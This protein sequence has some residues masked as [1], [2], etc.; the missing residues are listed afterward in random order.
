MVEI[1]SPKGNR[2]VSGTITLSANASDNV[3]VAVV[4][5]TLDDEQS[6]PEVT[7]PP[8]A[9]SVNTWKFT[10]GPHEFHA[11]AVD[12]FGNRATASMKVTI[13]NQG[14]P[15]TPPDKLVYDDE[16]RPPYT[17]TSWGA[18]I[19]PNDA[20]V[21]K[22]GYKSVKVDYMAW[23]A[24]DILSGTWGREVPIN[25]AEYDTLKLDAY[26]LGRLSMKVAFYNKFSTNIQLKENQWNSIAIPLQFT[27]P[28]SRF[29]LQSNLSKPITC[30]FDN[31][32]FVPKAYQ[33]RVNQ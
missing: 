15:P 32:R 22:S 4:E 28:F 27:E 19:Y 30:Y 6:G 16:L 3:G 10:N 11:T 8:Y 9:L 1:V 24:F 14:V 29:Y 13:N 12:A 33:V 20:S 21:V 26:P 7:A 23:G 25:P 2:A 17:N 18:N 5:Y 31:I